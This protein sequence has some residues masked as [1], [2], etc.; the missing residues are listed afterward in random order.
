MKAVL[1]MLLYGTPV[2]GECPRCSWMS[3]QFIR[4]LGEVILRDAPCRIMLVFPF[5]DDTRQ[6]RVKEWHIKGDECSYINICI[7]VIPLKHSGK[8]VPPP[9]TI[10]SIVLC[11]HCA[12]VGVCVF[13]MIQHTATVSLNSINRLLFVSE[14]RCVFCKVGS[15]P[16]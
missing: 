6:F 16:L 9:L 10:K 15:G 4:K 2:Q 1:E 7:V 14:V 13:R 12:C 5:C 8:Y 11:Q 3:F